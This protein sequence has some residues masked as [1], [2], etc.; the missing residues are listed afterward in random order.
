M[1]FMITLAV[2]FVIFLVFAAVGSKRYVSAMSETNAIL[3]R[4]TVS[5]FAL[6]INALHRASNGAV[7]EVVLPL[8][9]NTPGDY[10][11]DIYPSAH[12]VEL[13]YTGD[14]D[15]RRFA[16]PVLTS[17]FNGTTSGINKSVTLRNNYGV[18]QIDWA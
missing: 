4:E 3:A 2:M 18:I 10:R 15:V 8:G 12:I 6:H 1:D 14:V 7:Q 11:I 16:Y 5:T 17:N 9:I 13:T